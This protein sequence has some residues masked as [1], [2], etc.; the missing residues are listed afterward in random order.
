M[1]SRTSKIEVRVTPQEKAELERRAGSKGVS[2]YVRDIALAGK[3][4]SEAPGP[5]GQP[6]LPAKDWKARVRQ[7]EGQGLPKAAAM[8]VADQELG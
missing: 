5:S 2:A 8:K 4:E 7:L 1:A 3:A 6:V